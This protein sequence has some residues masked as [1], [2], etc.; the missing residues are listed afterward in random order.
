MSR[1]TKVLV[2]LGAASMVTAPVVANAAGGS[3]PVS[4]VGT[5]E[6]A[7]VEGSLGLIEIFGIVFVVTAVGLLV[8][9][10]KSK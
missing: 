6:T 7:E 1:F 5:T 10:G 8:L 4:I 9:T 3:L 2:L